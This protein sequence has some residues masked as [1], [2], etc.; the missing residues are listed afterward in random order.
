MKNR[1]IK[2]RWWNPQSSTFVKDYRYSGALEELFE[3]DKF[4]IPQQ[5]TGLVDKHGIDIYEGD[6][7]NFKTNN[8]VCLGDLDIMEWDSEEVYWDEYTCSFCFERRYG[9]SVLDK[10]MLETLEIVGNIFET[11]EKVKHYSEEE[12]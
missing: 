4:L 8:T 10:I 2:F 3:S 7:I 9:T 5:W 11:P 12:L 1:K 6:L